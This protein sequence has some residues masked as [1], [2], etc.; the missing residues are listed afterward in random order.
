MTMDCCPMCNGKVIAQPAL[1]LVHKTYDQI[2]AVEGYVCPQCPAMFDAE[3]RCVRRMWEK[4]PGCGG[5][6]FLK[7]R[8]E[9]AAKVCH[10]KDIAALI[11]CLGCSKQQA[12]RIVSFGQRG[13]DPA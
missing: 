9:L 2:L 4:C 5:S 11:C 6:K 10:D 1:G 13:G 8:G 12:I 7:L 3:G